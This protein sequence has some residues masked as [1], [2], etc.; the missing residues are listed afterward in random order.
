MVYIRIQANLRYLGEAEGNEIEE[1]LVPCSDV[2][3]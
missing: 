1:E 3:S 2:Y